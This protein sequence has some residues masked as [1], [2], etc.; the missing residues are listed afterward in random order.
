MYTHTH[1]HTHTHR[2]LARNIFYT[3]F[4]DI[5]KIYCYCFTKFWQFFFFNCPITT[6]TK[7][8]RSL[9]FG[10]FKP[11]GNSNVFFDISACSCSLDVF[12]CNLLF[13]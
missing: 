12:P 8:K 5:G 11:I 13:T 1:T 9:N 3:M 2:V 10:S 4:F 7:K 6:I